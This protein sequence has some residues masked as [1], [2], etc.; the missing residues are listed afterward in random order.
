MYEN[1][2]EPPRRSAK[3]TVERLANIE[4][5]AAVRWEWVRS[6]LNRLDQRLSKIEGALTGYSTAPRGGS[7]TLVIKDLQMLL[8]AALVLGAL[9]GK[10]GVNPLDWLTR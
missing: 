2:D 4:T 9:L 3:E 7:I 10:A 6:E 1:G 5:R 8:I